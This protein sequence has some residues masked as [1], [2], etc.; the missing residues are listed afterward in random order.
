MSV[1]KNT[2]FYSFALVFQKI[3]GFVYFAL[4]ARFLGVEN[5]GLY[6]FALSFTAI[7]SVLADLG[8][9]PILTREIAKDKK[10]TQKLFS[11]VFSVKII[12]SIVTYGLVVLAI[13]ALGYSGFTRKLVYM[14]GAV[15][16]LDSFSLI[17]WAVFRGH[18][19]LRYEA[20][21]VVGFQLVTVGFG[22]VVL[23]SGFGVQA[24]IVATL[25]GS[26]FYALFSLGW[27]LKKLQLKL[28][29]VYDWVTIKWMLALA[30]P[31]ALAGVFARIYTQIDTV[32]ISKMSCLPNMPQICDQYVGW[33]GTAS[34]VILALQ[35]IPMALSA[36]L[37]PKLSEQAVSS[38]A[39]SNENLRETFVLSWRYLAIVGLPMASGVIVFAP[40]VIQAVWGTAFLPA[41]LPLQILIGSLVF[42]FLTFPNGA[43]LN[44]VGKQLKNTT[45][46]GIVVVVN[47]LLNMWLIPQYTMTG[48]AIASLISTS[49]LFILGFIAVH[50]IIRFSFWKLL[51]TLFVLVVSAWVMVAVAVYLQLFI[52]WILAGVISVVVYVSVA[53]LLGGISKADMALI[54]Q[55]FFV[56][57]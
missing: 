56:R 50:K 42:L 40:H 12:M 52:H 23:Y 14:A 19:N 22:L 8:F 39:K 51:Y 49:T 38:S 5:T 43:L 15:M 17:F 3:L 55:V 35:F 30:F 36:S 34:K 9:A 11:Q 53:W 41:S 57:D 28:Q 45:F 7:F 16:V 10:E 25:A 18:Q 32:M 31:F 1:A 33:Y 27:L 13:N 48:A 6:V 54:K 47:V 4:I 44:A 26:L 2:V 24:L 37:F 20:Y 29:F 46:M 21:G